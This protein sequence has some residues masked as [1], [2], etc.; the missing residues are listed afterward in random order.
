[1]S[2]GLYF[3]FE[4]KMSEPSRSIHTY[5]THDN[6]GRPFRV[7]VSDDN[8][9]AVFRIL[10]H[11]NDIDEKI[12]DTYESKPCIRLKVARAFIGVSPEIAMTKV[13]GGFG[14][15]FKGN[16]IL[17]LTNDVSLD[18][19]LIGIDIFSFKAKGEINHFVSPV[20]NNDTPYP[21]CMDRQGSTYLLCEKVVIPSMS[22]GKMDPYEW[23]YANAIICPLQKGKKLILKKFAI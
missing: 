12:T 10:Q 23:Y 22:H 9:V 13:S 6:G 17:L 4:Y 21:Y 15:K 3:L 5:F 20:G 18:Y 7:Q 11:E 19:V 8:K 16:S 14:P 1:M 2:H